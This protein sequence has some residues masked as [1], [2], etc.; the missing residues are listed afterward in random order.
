M[1]I[2]DKV[3][4][5]NSTR[6]YVIPE[7]IPSVAAPANLPASLPI[8]LVTGSSNFN[9]NPAP[10]I[11]EYKPVAASAA[12]AAPMLMSAVPL[13]N[14]TPIVTSGFSPNL[15]TFASKDNPY[16]ALASGGGGSFTPNPSFSTIAMAPLG[17]GNGA[18]NFATDGFIGYS[19]NFFSIVD[20]GSQNGF[21]VGFQNAPNGVSTFRS[22]MSDEIWTGNS[23]SMGIGQDGNQY[24]W[25]GG[26]GSTILLSPTIIPSLNTSSLT[27]VYGM[28]TTRLRAEEDGDLIIEELS[29]AEGHLY[30]ST[31]TTS[32]MTT[33]FLNLDGNLLTTDNI[34]PAGELLLN[35]IP[36]ATT[37][38]L[39]SIQDWA[40]YNAASTIDA[41]NNNIEAANQI[42]AQNVNTS[43]IKTREIN[44]SSI[45]GLS[46]INNIPYL[47]TQNWWQNEAMGN[48]NFNN[49]NIVDVDNIFASINIYGQL[50]ST[51][52]LNVSTGTFTA[53]STQS[54]KVSTIN[55]VAYPPP[56]PSSISSFSTFAVSS[57]TVNSINGTPYSPAGNVADW[58]NFPAS[59]NVIVS[60]KS[61]VLS[62]GD[63][64]I[65]ANSG[66]IFYPNCQWDANI[67]VGNTGNLLFPNM[68]LN[69]ANFN[70]GTLGSPAT[71][72]SMDSLAAISLTS[73]EGVNITGVGGVSLIGGGGITALGATINLGAGEIGMA[74]G[75]VEIGGGNINLG[76]GLISMEGG[77]VTIGTG[78][79]GILGGT[80]D[81][82]AGLVAVG[83]GSI[84]V[85][86]G[87]IVLGTGAAAGGGMTAYGGQI[88]AAP[89]GLG[90]N[91]GVRIDGIAA[92]STNTITA[93]DSGN[94]QIKNLSSINGLPYL[95]AGGVSTFSQLFTSTLTASTIYASDISTN[96][97][98]VST[99]GQGP[100]S[101]IKFNDEGAYTTIRA[102]TEIVL[103]AVG[104]SFPQAGISDNIGSVGGPNQFLKSGA[105]GGAVLW[106]NLTEQELPPNPLFSTITMFPLSEFGGQITYTTGGQINYSTSMT[107]VDNDSDG[108]ASFVYDTTG[109]VAGVSTL[110]SVITDG[111]TDRSIG[112]YIGGNNGY[113]AGNAT[114][115]NVLLPTSI[116]SLTVSSINGTSY[117]PSAPV[118]LGLQN[119]LQIV[120]TLVG[121]STSTVVY[122]T[123]G[124][125]STWIP[126][127]TTYLPIAG[128]NNNG[129]RQFK[130]VGTS[131][132]STKAA[133]Y[134]YNP[135]Y[136]QSLPYTVN[137]SPVILKKNLNSLWAVIFTKNRINIQGEIFFNIFTYDVANPPTSPGNTFTNRFDY[138]IFNHTTLLG[139]AVSGTTLATLNGGHRYLI[140]AVDPLH[141]T[142]PTLT[143]VA[144]TAMITGNTYTIL[145]VAGTNWTAIGAAVA[146]V[147][148]V[149]VKNATA[150]TGSGTGTIEVNTSILIGNGQYP[151]QNSQQKLRDPYDIYT[152]LQHI[153]FTAV[154]VASN[155]PQPADPASVAVSAIA[156]SITSSAISPTLDWTLEAIGY[157]ANNGAQN[158]RYIMNYS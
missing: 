28:S 21:N 91:G 131:G 88:I 62:N 142:Q 136:G 34:G 54:I 146:T 47:P 48:V 43:S 106:G 19:G 79:L 138:S 16:F 124:S 102:N 32:S 75:T 92:L 155:N 66:S 144:A 69:V 40:F 24:I 44:T 14:T 55:G 128:G 81:V 127:N 96:T 63:F 157:S 132:N 103:E 154:A 33:T 149:F 74:G 78:T 98:T 90:G 112:L 85:G 31:V 5:D 82:G 56:A 46:S 95:P 35:G 152:D 3:K 108:T 83:S 57:F 65:L 118:D 10:V 126:D 73:A 49:Y 50:I 137:P 53:I 119:R 70:I 122:T 113:I 133:W 101:Y 134:P 97:I 36:I 22:Q 7:K 114:S 109:I 12:H 17:G 147:G 23:A 123:I 45:V 151:T 18:I 139:S 20:S 11:P 140:C 25:N 86:A 61:I 38:N 111:T 115:L 100:T 153:P 116:S 71:S 99:I 1:P 148:C 42:F 51:Q 121:Q 87:Q 67:T 76:A 145:T 60:G 156:I 37:A 125:P 27:L 141:I 120:P 107:F 143:T 72:I 105:S 68:A 89:S 80:V 9:Y 15:E 30:C 41:N 64:N 135:F 129:W 4:P 59:S 52:L 2:G 29:G 130:E 158:E 150:A 117:P 104:V 13:T 58:A 94:L 26:N 110:G 77:L 39:S 8:S 84:T 93:G 6:L